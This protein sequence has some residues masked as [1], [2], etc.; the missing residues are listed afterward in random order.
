MR[1]WTLHP[2]H[3][4]TKGL[5][6]AWREALLA[7]KVLA[8][9]TT[10]YR[11]HPQLVRFRD[12]VDPAGAIGAFLEGLLHESVRRGYEFD[13]RRIAEHVRPRRIVETRGQVMFEWEHL[14][15]KLRTRSPEAYRRIR[16]VDVP[17]VH[18]LFRVVEGAVRD[19]ER[20]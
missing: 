1:L 6:A 19:W 3:L 12:H 2:R 4:D 20:G 17:E 18:P 9:G 8:G 14:K 5:V 15:R 16:G 11:H 13:G 7:Q 10:G